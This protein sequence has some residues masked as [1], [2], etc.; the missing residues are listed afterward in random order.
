M[1]NTNIDFWMRIIENPSP[2]Y[3][4]LF[5]QE[6]IYLTSKIL[7]NVNVLDVGCGDGRIIKIIT[8]NTKNIVGIDNDPIAIK[9]ARNQLIE[10]PST[11]LVEGDGLNM[12]FVNES[13][14][15]IVFMMTLVNF[16]N[17]KISVLKEINR[18]LKRD[19]ILL[20][21][22][23]SEDAYETRLKMYTEI[24]LPIKNYE[25]GKFVFN[26]MASAETSQQFS[27]EELSSLVKEGGFKITDTYKI[28]KIAYICTLQK[29]SN[30]I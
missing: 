30:M 8:E 24:G 19:G 20:L 25:N 18:V 7:P 13:F 4:E 6:K 16:G 1:T 9:N 26:A 11:K 2:I 14:D 28:D 12:P 3:K 29:I 27:I 23:Y 15:I 17:N 5:K 22:V 21:S 10:F